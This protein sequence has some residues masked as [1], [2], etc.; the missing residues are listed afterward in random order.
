MSYTELIANP[1]AYADPAKRHAMQQLLT[2]LDGTLEARG[3]VLVKLN[4]SDADFDARDRAR[5]R[6]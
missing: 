2:L 5:C 1:A 3:K 6:R 4:V